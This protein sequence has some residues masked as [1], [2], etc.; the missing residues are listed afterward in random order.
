MN[1]FKLLI[2][3]SCLLA[4]VLI[5]SKSINKSIPLKTVLQQRTLHTTA[6]WY[7]LVG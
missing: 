1:I 5:T 2:V 7:K 3:Q 4:I 6:E